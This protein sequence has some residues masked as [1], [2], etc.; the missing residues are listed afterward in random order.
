MKDS[1]TAQESY[2]IDL[3]TL[4]AR[5]HLR[6]PTLASST[7]HRSR[8]FLSQARIFAKMP[9]VR[10]I[11][12]ETILNLTRN[13]P[14]E[15]TAAERIS[16][17]YHIRK[18][19]VAYGLGIR[20]ATPPALG[21]ATNIESVQDPVHDSGARLATIQGPQ[22]NSGISPT[23]GP[24]QNTASA[25]AAATINAQPAESGSSLPHPNSHTLPV[26][27][28]SSPSPTTTQR[29]EPRAPPAG[30]TPTQNVAQSRS[31]NT[32]DTVKRMHTSFE[33]HRMAERYLGL[34]KR[35]ESK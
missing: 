6:L 10:E 1:R 31:I 5:F 35:V 7:S 26:E 3:T 25:V 20:S 21:P 30:A 34:R 33:E 8:F 29:A 28:R 4:S 22:P 27:P 23:N 17:T 15:M 24:S 2:R 18:L 11:V 12:A 9:S 13:L 19:V 14:H 16:L 32:T